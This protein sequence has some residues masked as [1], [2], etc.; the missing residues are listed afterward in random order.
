M[1]W[2][3]FLLA[4][5]VKTLTATLSDSLV[6][7]NVPQSLISF[8]SRN[9]VFGQTCNPYNPAYIS[10]GS[11][12]GEAALLACDGVAFGFGSDIAG[13]LRIPTSHCGIYALKPTAGRGFPYQGGSVEAN[14]GF[15]AVKVVSGPMCR[16]SKDLELLVRIF[17][18]SLYPPPDSVVTQAEVQKRFGN[19]SL[20][21]S[22]LRPAWLQPLEAAK[23]RSPLRRTLRVGYYYS[24][25]F[26]RTSPAA[27]RCVDVAKAALESLNGTDGDKGSKAV[28]LVPIESRRLRGD[29]VGRIFLGLSSA[30]GFSNL[31]K[32]MG[33]D[34]MDISLWLIMLPSLSPM[35]RRIAYFVARFL[36]RDRQL[37][38]VIGVAGKK[39][40][41]KFLDIN[42][43]KK[44][45]AADFER[46]VW[47]AQDLD[48]IISPTMGVPAMK[49]YAPAQLSM[50]ASATILYN[51][52][53]APVSIVPVTRVNAELD[54]TLPSR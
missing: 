12:G 34:A 15:E 37:A 9:P 45:Y 8:E 6:K 19:E 27:V 53:D 23:S 18:E 11:S 35:L 46:D 5:T 33:P 40:T 51:I 26:I 20:L 44:R 22:P 3:L 47:Q 10:G 36:L 28:E 38:E 50:V 17:Y 21:Y 30:D 13:S 49:H 52:I 1:R 16:S 32:P 48:A 42:A 25:G 4:N 2:L 54:S 29:L 24:D 14:P 7:T 43:E 39:W 41:T 31:R